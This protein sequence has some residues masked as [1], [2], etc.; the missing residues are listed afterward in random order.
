VLQRDWSGAADS[1]DAIRAADRRAREA[2]SA[3]AERMQK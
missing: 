2:A 3:E 1:L